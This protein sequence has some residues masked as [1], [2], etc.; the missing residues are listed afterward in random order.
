METADVI[1]F[2]AIA[3]KGVVIAC[4]KRILFVPLCERLTVSGPERCQGSLDG[5]A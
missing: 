5:K 4:P 1:N 3:G 2:E